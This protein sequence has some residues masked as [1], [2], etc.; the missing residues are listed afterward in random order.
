MAHDLRA[1]GREA[2]DLATSRVQPM[3]T[4]ATGLS[5]RFFRL[6]IPIGRRVVGSSIGSA[7]IVGWVV[8]NFSTV[9]A[10]IVKKCPVARRLLRILKVCVTTVARGGSSP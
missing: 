8:G 6:M 4:W 7:L 3:K 5:A 10:S 9:A 1:C 2:I